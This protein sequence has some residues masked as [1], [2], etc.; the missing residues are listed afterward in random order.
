LQYP[1][2]S[3]LLSFYVKSHNIL[4]ETLRHQLEKT[5][6]TN[7]L[8]IQKNEAEQANK[9]KSRF[10]AAASHDLRQPIHAQ[11]LLIEELSE[12]NHDLKLSNLIRDIKI[13]TNALHGLFDALLDISK[14]DSG[15]V[16]PHIEI[17]SLRE[18][19]E[20]IELEY[21]SIA[22]DKQLELRIVTPDVNVQSD[23]NLL[24][25]IIHNL[26]S[27]ALKH[28]L[29]GSILVAARRRGELKFVIRELEFRLKNKLKYLKNIIK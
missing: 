1:L 25:R 5:E 29:E 19:L 7:L 13:S 11:T 10:L 26:V 14:L 16:E 28:T 15:T 23:R 6:L 18:M 8:E 12:R 20:T 24:S 21:K 17:F 22:K 3:I 27:N 2:Y 4:K 9:D